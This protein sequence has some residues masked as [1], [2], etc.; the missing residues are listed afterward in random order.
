MLSEFTVSEK[1]FEIDRSKSLGSG[2][3]GDVFKGVDKRTAP[4]IPVAVKIPNKEVTFDDW[5]SCLREL[6]VLA[7]MNHAGVLQLIG[8][9][10]PGTEN[11]GPTILTPLMP[12][13]TIADLLKKE[14]T[15][16]AD[17]RWD[18]TKKSICVFGVAASMAY[19]HSKGILHRDLKPAN[20]F[21]NDQFEPV[22]GDFGLARMVDL[23]MT[24]RASTIATKVDDASRSRCS[25]GATKGCHSRLLLGFDYFLLGQEPR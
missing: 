12:G 2:S 11:C 15:G 18:P 16:K 25:L 22:I 10:I 8:F 24:T 19:V 14:H 4:P 5:K 9:S 7:K 17:P 13:G 6:S 23:G 3:Y 21:V 1:E 20:V